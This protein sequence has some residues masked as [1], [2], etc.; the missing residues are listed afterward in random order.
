MRLHR[1]YVGADNNSSSLKVVK[2]YFVFSQSHIH[3]WRNVFRFGVGDEIII[4]DGVDT[5]QYKAR[6][7]TLTKNSAVLEIFEKLVLVAKP[8]QE[9]FLYTALIKRERFEWMVEKATEIGVSHFC[10]IFSDRTEIKDIKTERIR[11]IIIEA[12]E[13]AG[14]C[15]L[16]LF[17][18]PMALAAAL[19][20]ARNSVVCDV[21]ESFFSIEKSVGS[22]KS[23]S[24]FIGPEGGWSPA[25]KELFRKKKIPTV[26]LGKQTLRSETAAIVAATL[27]L[28]ALPLQERR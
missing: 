25:E 22:S 1:F 17:S 28:L 19:E 14:W 2:E 13:Q 8:V 23:T 24:I 7:I 4:F 6:F 11:K 10:P 21:G 18:A 3:Q 5:S 20:N 27:T 15:H 26:S 12:T 9:I 16:P